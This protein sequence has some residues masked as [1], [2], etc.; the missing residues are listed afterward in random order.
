M[1]YL[2]NRITRDL[3]EKTEQAYELKLGNF[4]F[5]IPIIRLNTNTLAQSGSRRARRSAISIRNCVVTRA[6]PIALATACS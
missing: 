3:L 4:D 6:N 1:S 2:A 5:G